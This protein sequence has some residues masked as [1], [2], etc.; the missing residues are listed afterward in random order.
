MSADRDMWLAS[1]ASIRASRILRDSV[2]DSKAGHREIVARCGTRW[3]E[4]C[5]AMDVLGDSSLALRAAEERLRKPVA[6]QDPGGRYI[7]IYGTFQA[8][9]LQQD[10]ADAIGNILGNHTS[11]TQTKEIRQIRDVRSKIAG[12]PLKKKVRGAPTVWGI[13]RRSIRHPRQLELYEWLP[14]RPHIRMTP[15]SLI[16]LIRHQARSIRRSVIESAR[17]ARQIGLVPVA[18]GSP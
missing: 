14:G 6:S 13:S 5:A 15:F 4:F 7:D 1:S 3:H 8:M 16:D 2:N 18:V 12:H 17:S 9:I 11:V 10:A